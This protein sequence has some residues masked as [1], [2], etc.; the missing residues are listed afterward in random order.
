MSD[1]ANDD[2]KRDCRDAETELRERANDLW[3]ALPSQS[4]EKTNALVDAIYFYMKA[5]IRAESLGVGWSDADERA[6]DERA[7][8][9]ERKTRTYFN[10]FIEDRKRAPESLLEV[11]QYLEEERERGHF[12]DNDAIRGMF[13]FASESDA[14]DMFNSIMAQRQARLRIEK[15]RYR[16][17]AEPGTQQ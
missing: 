4:V 5:V 3:H 10:W 16:E 12:V 11:A 2:Y 15:R 9:A 14:P 8:V 17:P 1:E 7:I 6:R 13:Y